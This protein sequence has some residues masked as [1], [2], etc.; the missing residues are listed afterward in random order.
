VYVVLSSEQVWTPSCF[1]IFK[2]DPSSGELELSKG[3]SECDKEFDKFANLRGMNLQF[4][5]DG[6]GGFISTDMHLVQSFRHDPR[7][8]ELTDITDVVTPAL[9]GRPGPLVVYDAKA[10]FLFGVAWWQHEAYGGTW[11]GLW[12]AKTGSEQ[13]RRGSRRDINSTPAVGA[14]KP[15]STDDWP[16][17]RGPQQDGKSATKG[18]RKDWSGGLKKVWEVTGLSP[19]LATWSAPSVQGDKLIVV[20]KHG[21]LDQVLC[22]NADKGGAPLWIAE[23]AGDGGGD[24]WAGG[25]VAQPYIDGDKVYVCHAASRYSC[26]SMTDGRLLWKKSFTQY[27]HTPGNPPVIWEDLVILTH[28]LRSETG[29]RATLA[30][31][32]KDTGESVWS[33]G[34]GDKRIDQTWLGAMKLKVNGKDQLVYNTTGFVCGLDP[35]T[36]KLLWEMVPNPAPTGESGIC[37]DALTDGNTVVVTTGLQKKP[38]DLQIQRVALQIENGV[39]KEVWSTPGVC[40]GWTDPILKDGYLYLFAPDGLYST[41]NSSFRCID[42]KTGQEKWIEKKTPCGSI[43]EVDGCLLCLTY[44]GDLWLL[45]PSPEGFKKMTEWKGAV[46]I[47]TWWTH[48]NSPA[49]YGGLPCWTIPVIARGKMYL[50]YSDT[51]TCYDLV[52]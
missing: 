33:Y 25:P 26:L 32:K 46:K 50:R 17:W 39:A 42:M 48:R 38:N 31:F 35:R 3:G 43:V 4:A 14:A 23:L 7:T 40:T 36:G 11:L 20:G 18:I 8:G 2:R 44:G 16:C 27:S 1:G 28:V 15:A 52:E 19:Y 21:C 34:E 51:L 41:G 22:L 29:K 45:N 5:P 10:G 13:V 6:A 24:G 37:T 47:Q 30:A 49:A 12:A 9:K